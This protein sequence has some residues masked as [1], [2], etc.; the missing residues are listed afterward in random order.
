M[1]FRRSFN[2][3][4]PVNSIKKVVETGGALAADTVSANVILNT[5]AGT[6]WVDAGDSSVPQA[7]HVYGLFL[8]LYVV[9]DGTAD[10]TAPIIDWFIAKNP[11]GSLTLP[12]PGSTG[13]NENRRFILHEGKG[14]VGFD[15]VTGGRKLFEG[16]IKIPRHMQR[17]G[18]DDELTVNIESP[19]HNAQFC[20]KAIYKFYQ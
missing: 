8:S 20:L 15:T 12:A 14:L 9:K 17:M 3:L 1:A 19:G 4:R 5:T 6:A 7:C 10:A 16:V 18:R 2:R 13:G 11:S